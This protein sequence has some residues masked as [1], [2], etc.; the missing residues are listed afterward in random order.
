MS[1]KRTIEPLWK[2]VQ[3]HFGHNIDLAL[4]DD[5]K[6]ILRGLASIV[7]GVDAYHTHIGPAHERGIALP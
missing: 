4:Q 7:D 2:V 1:A 5:Q 3:Q 6:R